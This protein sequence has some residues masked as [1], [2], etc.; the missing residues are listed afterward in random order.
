MTTGSDTLLYAIRSRVLGRFPGQL[1]LIL[2]LLTLVPLAV[3]IYFGDYHISLRYGIVIL[4]LVLLAPPPKQ[5]QTNEALAFVIAPL[6]MT[7]PMT[8][9]GSVCRCHV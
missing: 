4:M 5:I 7:I 3:S 6:F 1:A 9:P 2:V 8:V